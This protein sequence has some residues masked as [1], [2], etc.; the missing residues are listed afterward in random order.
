M[1]A[2]NGSTAKLQELREK[3][4]RKRQARLTQKMRARRMT[5]KGAA[6][7]D[8]AKGRARKLPAKRTASVLCEKQE[9]GPDQPCKAEGEHQAATDQ[10]GHAAA[11]ASMGLQTVSQSLPK[12]AV[13]PLA[14]AHALGL[15]HA[16]PQERAA[17]SEAASASAQQSAAAPPQQSSAA[18]QPPLLE[19]RIAAHLKHERAGLPFD[20]N[21]AAGIPA[22]MS[23]PVA[24][25]GAHQARASTVI[26]SH[27][28]PQPQAPH[29]WQ[30]KALAAA[31]QRAAV[32]CA[33][34][35]A[36]SQPHAQHAISCAAAAGLPV[37]LLSRAH[38]SLSRRI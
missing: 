7:A 1:P 14:H 26:T 31:Q 9:E 19:D 2:L 28:L 4:F 38:R 20:S 3:H 22:L 21:A 8:S 29:A 5:A 6:L 16:L 33:A 15:Q 30:A 34:H 11:A 36:A 17:T 32:D 13:K 27:N 35:A 12:P 24:T 10:E 18:M 25:V 37:S 23:T